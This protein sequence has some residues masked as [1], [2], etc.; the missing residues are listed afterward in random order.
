MNLLLQCWAQAL[1]AFVDVLAA[2]MLLMPF[3][4][5]YCKSL[6]A[7]GEPGSYYSSLRLKIQPRPESALDRLLS[8][9]LQAQTHFANIPA[10]RALSFR[11][12]FGGYR[13]LAFRQV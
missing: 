11:L 7:R 5:L 13:L 3:R 2:V 9:C 10:L 8:F 6:A 4:D 1:K 12:R